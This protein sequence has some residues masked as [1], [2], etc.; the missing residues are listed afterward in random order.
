MQFYPNRLNSNSNH[1]K[2]NFILLYFSKKKILCFQDQPVSKVNQVTSINSEKSSSRPKSS[3]ID[4]Q[5][6]LVLSTNH[7]TSPPHSKSN[8]LSLLDN[9]PNYLHQLGALSKR[10]NNT[11]CP[12]LDPC[13]PSQ[14]KALVP[15][16]HPPTP[17][18]LNF[19]M[20]QSQI[21]SKINRRT[22]LL[23]QALRWV[24]ISLLDNTPNY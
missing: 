16:Q 13:A 14:S 8:L 3:P 23:L 17:N 12:F 18:R 2:T 21:A 4:H 9:A 15:R 5:R 24:S 20:I 1:L 6:L 7:A 22:L 11:I 10:E 19:W